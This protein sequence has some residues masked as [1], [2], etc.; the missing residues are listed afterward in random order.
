MATA[1]NDDERSV[2]RTY[3]AAIRMGEDYVTLE[4]TVTLPVD[5][6]DDDVTKAVDLGWRIYR[7]QKEALDAQV[8]TMRDAQGA[9]APIVVRDPE[10]PASDKQ[11]N[12]I[13]ALQED[14]AWSAEQLASYAHDQSVDLVTMTKGQAS[15]FIDGMKRMAED[16][17]RHGDQASR[18]NTSNV[19]SSQPVTQSAPASPA[20]A[21]RDGSSITERQLRALQRLAQDRGL[22]LDAESSSRF[23]A[24]STDI[25]S[26]QAAAMLGEWQRSVRA[27]NGRRPTPEPAL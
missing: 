26:E 22:D 17:T 7:A 24:T 16:R 20:A 11:R 2:T 4:E 12:Y 9:P 13:V 21:Q 23:G 8:Q 3:R 10:A 14:L 1:R 15:T 18:Q 5:A 27:T 6:S 19:P 25:T